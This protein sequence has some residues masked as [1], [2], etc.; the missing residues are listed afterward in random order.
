MPATSTPRAVRFAL[1]LAIVAVVTAVCYY[2]IH[3]N[4]TTVALMMLLVVLGVG[5]RWG[6]AE[7]T[8]TSIAAVLAF[9]YYFL[10]PVGTFTIVDPQNWVALF[11]F[12]VAAITTSQL[13]TR[14]QRRAKEA[15]LRKLES[16]RLYTLSRAMLTDEGADIQFGLRERSE[17]HTSELQS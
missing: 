6:L 13:S 2:G 3:A 9:N 11:A 4:A 12:L 5:T 1:C 15:L 8:F 17:E 7:A 14:A 10:P 16:E